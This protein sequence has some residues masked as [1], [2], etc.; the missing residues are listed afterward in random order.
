MNNRQRRWLVIW[1][2]LILTFLAVLTVVNVIALY[3]TL[4]VLT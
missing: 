1:L 2:A 4:A 3:F